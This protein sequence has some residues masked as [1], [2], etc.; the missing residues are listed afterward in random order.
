MADRSPPFASAL[1][2][3]LVPGRHGRRAGEPGVFVSELTGLGLATITA[4]KGQR[5]ALLEA[6]RAAF[7][8]E[9]PVLPR[10]IEGRGT[11]FIWLGPDQWLARQDPAPAAGMEAALAAAFS[12]L[13]ALVDQS[14]GRTVLSVTGPRIRDALAKGLPIDLHPRA[15]QPGHAA[16]TAVAHV[17]VHL[18]Q[19]D[20]RPTYDLSVARGFAQSFWHWLE[21][22]SA[23]YGLEAV[24]GE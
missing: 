3:V 7:G 16:V 4:R 12:G 10:K 18:W 2:G 11:A 9:L 24:S 21:A 22:S 1:D 5:E 20:E 14:H 17:G 15:F 8:V 19:V 6:A 23:E 13:A